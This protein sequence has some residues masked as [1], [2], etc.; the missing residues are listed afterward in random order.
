MGK[1]ISGPS[2]PGI[3]DIREVFPGWADPRTP[4]RFLDS[5]FTASD[6]STRPRDPFFSGTGRFLRVLWKAPKR[7]QTEI[8]REDATYVKKAE[9]ACHNLTKATVSVWKGP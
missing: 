2:A 8:A 3:L 4:T 5:V 9:N 1:E 6:L 7:A